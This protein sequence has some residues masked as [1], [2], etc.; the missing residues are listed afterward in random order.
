MSIVEGHDRN[1]LTAKKCEICA[2]KLGKSKS[3]LPLVAVGVGV[4]ALLGAGFFGYKTL[5]AKSDQPDTAATPAATTQPTTTPVA[6]ASTPPAVATGD[7]SAFLSQGER[8]L[9]TDNSNADK[10]AGVEA[11]A[12]GDFPTAVAKL[13]A[14]RKA[15]RNDPETLIYLNNARLGTGA[16]LTIAAIVP[17][18]SSPSSAQELLRGI[19]QA[20]DEAIQS[21]V[22]FKVLIG[23]DNNDPAQAET[24]ANAVVQ[25]SDAIAVI[26]HGTSR[27][28][29]AAAPIYQ[30]GGLVMI[31]P[32]S[33]S[34]ELAQ[35][36][37]GA[38]GN[39]IFRTIPSDQ[40][41][42]TTLAR[43]MLSQGLSKAAI[44]YNSTSSYSASLQEA[45]ATTI[46]LEGGQV[47]QQ[48]DLSQGNAAAQLAQSGADA[49]ALFPDS[50]TLPQALEVA[51][52]NQNRLP[53]LAGDA[54][55]RIET[56]QQAGASLNGAVLSVPWHPQ[57]SADPSFA[58]KGADLWGGD[59]NWRSALSYD[60]LRVIRYARSV[61]SVT[62]QSGPQGRLLLEQA[63]S[64]TSFST[65]GVTG[66]VSFLPS[67]DRNSGVI[68]VKIQPGSRSGTGF[69][70]VPF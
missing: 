58:V 43:H 30:Q 14:A 47:V 5:L 53:V 21:G 35:I 42:G 16:A 27:T 52:A 60:A 41:T 59:V 2:A 37:R 20:Q 19:A 15:L 39:F 22:P 40:F 13:E 36:P 7:A 50:E 67:G 51:K 32:T 62:P 26:G 1:T 66:S 17:I 65:S 48:I 6:T 8:V 55:Y 24:V 70:F 63:M 61:A 11:I 31:A 49:I 33:T 18:G 38:D 3:V 46:S 56:L 12:S 9:F 45:F 29:L 54:F 23:D 25:N 28:T 68:L 64:D 69:D 4:A 44:F 57:R 34:T 10:Q